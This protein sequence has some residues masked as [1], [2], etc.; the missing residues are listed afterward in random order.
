MFRNPDQIKLL[1]KFPRSFRVEAPIGSPKVRTP[2]V[3]EPK[4]VELPKTF[5]DDGNP[6]KQTAQEIIETV[7]SITNLK[8]LEP[9]ME[10]ELKSVKTA[11]EKR[12][13]ELS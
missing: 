7:E 10:H 9:F 11:A 4:K 3:E 2:K 12:F 13:N 5:M 6:K 8:E 1:S